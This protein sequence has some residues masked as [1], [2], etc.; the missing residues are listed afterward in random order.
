MYK[1]KSAS[2]D[3][4]ENLKWILYFM[5]EG[6]KIMIYWFSYKLNVIK[7]MFYSELQYQTMRIKDM[8]DWLWN[9][10]IWCI[11]CRISKKIF[12]MFLLLLNL[13]KFLL[14]MID[15]RSRQHSCG[16]T[17]MLVLLKLQIIFSGF[18]TGTVTNMSS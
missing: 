5:F 6:W 9:I 14:N 13:F 8:Q 18:K 2:T 3:Y 17:R 15:T 11:G 1:K 7:Q 10:F 12:V 16:I 4:F